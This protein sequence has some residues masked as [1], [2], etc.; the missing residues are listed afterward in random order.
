MGLGL[1]CGCGSSGLRYRVLH[2]F[3]QDSAESCDGSHAASLL[4]LR[5]GADPWG[6]RPTQEDP[7]SKASQGLPEF[8]GFR[9]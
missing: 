4:G 5:I 3:L 9:R 6:H 8:E 7:L 2:G 1:G